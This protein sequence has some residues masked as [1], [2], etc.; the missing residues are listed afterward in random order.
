MITWQWRRFSDNWTNNDWVHFHFL[1]SFYTLVIVVLKWCITWRKY[2]TLNRLQCCINCNKIFRDVPVKTIFCCS[3]TDCNTIYGEYLACVSRLVCNVCSVWP[4]LLL[5]PWKQKICRVSLMFS[6]YNSVGVPMFRRNNILT[7]ESAFKQ[8]FVRLLSEMPAIFQNKT[9]MKPSVNRKSLWSLILICW[10]KPT[11][12]CQPRRLRCGDLQEKG[13]LL[14][15]RSV[16]FFS[17]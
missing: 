9:R 6:L 11:S 15:T 4:C 8:P 5:L 12:R 13:K 7:P 14:M 17:R 3:A 10:E 16:T 2:G 1:I